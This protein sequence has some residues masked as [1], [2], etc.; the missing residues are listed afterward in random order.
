[1]SMCSCHFF[2]LLLLLLWNGHSTSLK[3]GV[4]WT[5]TQG[6]CLAFLNEFHPAS[7]AETGPPKRFDAAVGVVIWQ[8]NL[9]SQSISMGNM[10]NSQ[11]KTRPGL[12][13]PGLMHVFVLFCFVF[14][15]ECISG[16][17]G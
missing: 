10:R 15:L 14:L 17:E 12:G 6:Q 5:V 8:R 7:P 11:Q 3:A 9:R 2:S 16:A 13:G 1:M 4:I